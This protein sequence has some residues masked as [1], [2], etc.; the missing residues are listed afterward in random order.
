MP[1]VILTDERGSPIGQEEIIKAH[2]G[3]GRLHK[4]FSVYV[5]RNARSQILIQRRSMKKML[6]PHI[7]ANTACSHPFEKESPVEAGTRR[8][9]Q[10]MGITCALEEAGDLVYRAEDPGRGVEHEHV[11]LLVGDVEQNTEI[12]SNPDEVAEWK[13]I[14]IGAL[15]KDMKEHPDFYAPWFQLVLP[16]VLGK[17]RNP[18]PHRIAA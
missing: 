3:E 14:N 9:K 7:W 15:E 11:T 12:N 4:A 1:N 8:L 10:E 13:W 17:G 2:T 18:P 6:W 16:I 5:F